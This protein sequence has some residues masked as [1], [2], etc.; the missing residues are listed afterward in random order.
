MLFGDPD[1]RP[2]EVWDAAGDGTGVGFTEAHAGE[3]SN[4][5]R[6]AWLAP[7]YTTQGYVTK[8]RSYC[9]TGDFFCQ[10]TP[11]PAGLTVHGSYGASNAPLDAWT[12]TVQSL[13]D[14]S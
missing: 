6:L 8:V 7:A 4:M 5:T 9:F 2:G 12:F 14:Y 13:T 10:S 11:T 3:L 1:Y